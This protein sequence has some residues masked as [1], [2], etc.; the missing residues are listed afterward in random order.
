MRS[1]VNRVGEENINNFG[2]KMIIVR[3]RKY[4]DIDVYFPEYNWTF[5]NTGYNQFKKGKIKCPYEP[6]VYEHGCLGEGKYKS[7]ENGEHTKCYEVWRSMLKR[8]Y[9]FKFHEKESTYKGCEVYKD[10]LNFQNFGLWFDDNYYEIEG[11]KMCLDKDILVKDNKIYSPETSVFVPEKINLLFAKRQNHRGEYPI[12][13]SYDKYAKKFISQC[14]IYDY[15][16]NKIERKR[17]GY[18]ETSEE[19]FES[20]KKFKEQNIK[21]AA[22]YYKDKIPSKLYNAMYNYQVE[23]TD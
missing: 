15:E 22:D 17:L 21:E 19:A 4:S 11:E 23:I 6:R 14:S 10:L 1:K 3:Y 16:E 20:Y 5:K 13:V 18:Y 9:D 2:S 8:C 7:K 12:G